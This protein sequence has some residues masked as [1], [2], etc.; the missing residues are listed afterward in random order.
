MNL[1]DVSQ[2]TIPKMILV[3]TPRQ[4]GALCTRSF[5]PHKCHSTIG[6]FAAV[7]VASACLI[8]G[9]VT[10]G[11]AQ[12]Q[13]ADIQQVSIEHPG[14]AFEIQLRLE[15]GRLVACGLVRSARLILD[16]RVHIPESA[17]RP[18]R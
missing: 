2:R 16:G 5:I 17:Y 14:G 11:L 9:S 4:G 8:T 7:S 6:V 15:G 3:A 13:P 12:I 10:D 18:P 1:G